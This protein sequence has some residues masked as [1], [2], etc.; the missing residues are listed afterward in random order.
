MCIRTPLEQG[1]CPFDTVVDE[2]VTFRSGGRIILRAITTKFRRAITLRRAL[3]DSRNVPAVRLPDHVEFIN[4]IDLART[5]GITSPLP[6]YLPLAL[7]AADLNSMEHI[8]AFT[9]FPDD[10]IHIEPTIS[11]A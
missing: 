7:G 5:F 8:S 9:V 11:G 3:A 6:P 10:G 1:I 2:P 4:V